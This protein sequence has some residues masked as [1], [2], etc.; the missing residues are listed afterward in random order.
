M[1]LM[2]T[3]SFRLQTPSS[4]QKQ[5]AAD[6]TDGALKR[7]RADL[8]ARREAS[9]SLGHMTLMLSRRTM[10]LRGVLAPL[11]FPHRSSET[12]VRYSR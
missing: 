3:L 12:S 1:A 8:D 5:T 11:H 10:F 6:A 9:C 2:S 4:P 7:C